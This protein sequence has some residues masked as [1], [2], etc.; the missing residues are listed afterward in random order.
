MGAPVPNLW[1]LLEATFG[2][3]DSMD[4]IEEEDPD[5]AWF[6]KGHRLELSSTATPAVSPETA[7]P[8]ATALTTPHVG[9]TSESPTVLC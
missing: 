7:I 9:A 6:A 4:R 8:R 2:G 1:D 3:S 5:I